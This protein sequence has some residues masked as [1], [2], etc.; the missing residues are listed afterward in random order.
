LLRRKFGAEGPPQINLFA[1]SQL[2]LALGRANVVHAALK[3]EPASRA[4]LARCRRLAAYRSTSCA[5]EPRE[6]DLSPEAGSG[7]GNGEGRAPGT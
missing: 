7:V 4:F 3:A 6:M 5:D 1:S 2:D